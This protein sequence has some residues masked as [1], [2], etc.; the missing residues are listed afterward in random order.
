MAS[1]VPL[2]P[3]EGRRRTEC[4]VFQSWYLE[5][6]SEKNHKLFRVKLQVDPNPDSGPTLIWLSWIRI[7]IGNADPDTGA[8]KFTISSLINLV[9]IR[10]S[11]EDIADTQH[12]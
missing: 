2:S 7:R 5:G 4:P 10:I 3:E 12:W 8:R 11:I 9:L 6:F 1:S